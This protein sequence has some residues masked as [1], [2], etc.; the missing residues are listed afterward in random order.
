MWIQRFRWFTLQLI[1]NLQWKYTKLWYNRSLIRQRICLWWL[2]W[3]EWSHGSIDFGIIKG[4]IFYVFLNL[5]LKL[6]RT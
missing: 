2:N 4:H 6:N 5:Y 1:Q 3:K